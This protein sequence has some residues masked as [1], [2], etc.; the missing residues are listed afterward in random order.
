MNSI[1]VLAGWEQG[2]LM[3]RIFFF[4]N[5]RYRLIIGTD[6]ISPLPEASEGIL[7]TLFPPSLF[8]SPPYPGTVS[9]GPYHRMLSSDSVGMPHFSFLGPWVGVSHLDVGSKAS[10]F[11]YN[12]SPQPH[13]LVV[14]SPCAIVSVCK[15]AYISYSNLKLSGRKDT[16]AWLRPIQLLYWRQSKESNDTLLWKLSRNVKNAFALF[17]LL[18]FSSSLS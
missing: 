16:G 4:F 13:G 7:F 2:L 5:T 6:K 3:A 14:L 9:T 17:L 10:S 8:L 18:L 15:R 12:T 1:P 11:T